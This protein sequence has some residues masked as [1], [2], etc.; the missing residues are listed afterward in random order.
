MTE[1]EEEITHTEDEEDLYD[2]ERPSIIHLDYRYKY[3]DEFSLNE[4]ISRLIN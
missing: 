1:S 2:L 4:S 3:R